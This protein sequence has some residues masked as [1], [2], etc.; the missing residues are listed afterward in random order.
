MIQRTHLLIIDDDPDFRSL[1][2]TILKAEFF[3]M[4]AA[5]GVTG[6]S[7]AASH[8]PELIVLD[9][10]MP[11]WDGVRVLQEL[12]ANPKLRSIPVLVLS[13]GSEREAVIQAR[14]SGADDYLIKN[15]RLKD[16]L[17]PRL[18]ALLQRTKERAPGFVLAKEGP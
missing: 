14:D 2:S 15:V 9:M 7:L 8:R 1:L 3:V 5:D 10:Q 13:A 18:Q 16:M 6:V 4:L 17:A 11:G 12:R